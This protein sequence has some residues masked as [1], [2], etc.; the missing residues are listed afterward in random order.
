MFSYAVVTTGYGCLFGRQ[1]KD[2]ATLMTVTH[3]SAF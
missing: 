3:S 2:H 1:S